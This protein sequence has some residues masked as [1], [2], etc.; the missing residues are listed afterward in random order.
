M[1]HQHIIQRLYLFLLLIASSVG[2]WATDYGCAGYQIF[3]SR[4]AVKNKSVTTLTSSNVNITFSSC[5][6]TRGTGNNAIYELT[7]GSTITVE[8][9]DGYAIRW[10]ILR[11]TE[12][13]KDYDNAEGINRIGGVTSGYSYYFEKNAVSNSQVSGANQNNLNDDNNN[14]VVTQYDATAQSVVITT[15]NNSSWGQFKVRDIIVGY[16]KVCKAAFQ[17]SSVSAIAYVTVKP[18]ISMNGY[19]GT[20]VLKSDN[21]NVATVDASNFTGKAFGS[22]TICATFPATSNYAKGESSMKVNIL[23]DP[24]TM[25]FKTVPPDVTYTNGLPVDVVIQHLGTY[26]NFSTGSGLPFNWSDGLSF[27]SNNEAVLKIGGIYTGGELR[28]GGTTGTATIT[29]QQPQNGHYEAASI[30]CT[31]TVVRSDKNGT[32]LIRDANEWKMFASLVNDKGLT[33]LN[34]KLDADIE[35]GTDITM[36]GTESRRYAGTFDGNG[37]SITMN[38]NGS[39]AIGP[40]RCVENASVKNLTVK[41]SITDNTSQVGGL[42]CT[43]YGKVTVSNCVSSLAL[44]APGY[45]GGLVYETK[46]GSTLTVTDCLMTGTFE[47]TQNSDSWGLIVNSNAST[48]TISNCLYT[49]ESVNNASGANISGRTYNN[50]YYLMPC[51]AGGAKQVTAA[52]LKSGEVAWLLQ[53]SRSGNTWGMSIGTDVQPLLT[54]DAA[55]RVYKVSFKQGDKELAARYANSGGTVTLPTIEELA[56]GNITPDNY[57]KLSFGDGFTASTQITAD[58]TVTVT[59]TDLDYYPIASAEDWKAFTQEVKNGNNVMNARLTADI[60]L[61]ATS[62][63]IGSQ[64]YSYSG[65]FD[66]NGHSITLNVNGVSA[67]APFYAI[68]NAA[69]KN[70]HTKGQIS[71]TGYV[72]SGLI[73]MA[74]GTNSISNCI[75]EVNITSSYGSGPCSTSGI[76]QY[77]DKYSN[78]TISDCVVMGTFN[79]TSYEGQKGMSGFCYEQNGQCTLNNCLYIGNNNAIDWWAVTFAK[80]ATLNNCYYLN[81]CG[82]A[83]GTPVTERQL[84]S[85]EV[86]K[87]LQNGRTNQ[88]YWAQVLGEMPGLYNEADKTKENY[89][90]YDKENSRWACEDFHFDQNTALPIGLDFTAVKMTCKQSYPSNSVKRT[91]CL[92]FD[93]PIEAFK[94]YT[95]S[96]CN[97]N[98]I[99]F[100]EVTDKIEAYHPYYIITD[101]LTN[102]DSENIEVRAFNADALKT[103]VGGYSFMG[104][105]DVIDNATAAA[106]N[107]YILQ[108]DGMF[109]KV[110]TGNTAV[111]IPPYRA[112]ITAPSSSSAKALS[113]ALDYEATGISTIETTDA[114][115]TVRYYDLQGR[116]IG[117]S[118]DGQPKGIYIRNGKKVINK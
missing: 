88:C 81:P 16:V 68:K 82:T 94:A 4:D 111:Y 118:L 32:V 22:T 38:W 74:Y 30:S 93:Y 35:L 64:Y 76:V 70:V 9:A 23:R 2:A 100:K 27:A 14:I 37:H 25:S 86:A 87:L 48:C 8:A 28:W 71:V 113:I 95:L 43:A 24:V 41:G 104:T 40:F 91:L 84:K 83:Q 52:Q 17:Q 51:N 49:G 72:S 107:A 31:F 96:G 65:V 56:G 19:D 115:G 18:G 53:N 99:Y 1:K 20:P 3:R 110:T 33:T 10:I 98:I 59:F 75:S 39:G 55:K 57:Y 92:P 114:D 89:V 109:H 105:A 108:G 36:V 77:I 73:N 13:G 66:G 79:A 46:T 112:Y 102:F 101:G 15:H 78:T 63:M 45:M 62:P 50:C 69:I 26:V 6:T 42:I 116:Y 11:D 90:Y 12:G 47:C 117:T 5:K 97:G 85:G 7:K 54:A 106:A 80:N 103:T 29:A 34:A 44:K 60:I 67:Y 21:N 58:R 61:D